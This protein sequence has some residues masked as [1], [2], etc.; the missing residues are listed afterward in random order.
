MILC[1]TIQFSRHQISID[2]AVDNANIMLSVQKKMQIIC[3]L[4]KLLSPSSSGI[5]FVTFDHSNYSQRNLEIHV[6]LYQQL[7]VFE[8]C[9]FILNYIAE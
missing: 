8:I 4:I 9:Q 3:G 1:G 6:H 7:H 2:E 5:M